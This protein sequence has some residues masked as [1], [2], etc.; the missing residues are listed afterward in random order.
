MPKSRTG[1]IR[2]A[3]VAVLTIILVG[4]NAFGPVPDDLRDQSIL[5]DEPCKAPCWYN[6]VPD[7]S[8]MQEALDVLANLAFINSAS[9][10]T[11][12]TNW[13]EAM[14]EELAPATS[15]LAN[16]KQ[17]AETTCVEILVFE[18][19]VKYISIFPNYKL[20]FDEVVNHTGEP[21]YINARPWGV[22]CLG[23]VMQ[24][25]WLR[26]STEILL[27]HTDSRCGAG[28]EICQD[29]VDGGKIPRG[30]EVKEIIYL[31]SAP[32]DYD[33]PWPGFAGP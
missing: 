3:L 33:M 32:Q 4:C 24:L 27:T 29:I 13:R 17:P 15:I 10:R 11:E 6:L 28:N 16:C 26:P 19:R 7:E 20:T 31:G 18:D 1:A 12:N 14:S 30:L 5:T 22:E 9:I 25:I 2:Y 23:C 21:D 8:S